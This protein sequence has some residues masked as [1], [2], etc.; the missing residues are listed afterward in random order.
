[1]PKT[2]KLSPKKTLRSISLYFAFLLLLSC[3]NHS[4]DTIIF[5]D[6]GQEITLNYSDL[7]EDLRIIELDNDSEVL[8][9]EVND[10]L[11]T[12]ERIIILDKKLSEAIHFYNNT[13]RLINSIKAEKG[14]QP[15]FIY[16]HT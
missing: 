1:M 15:N 2:S 9:A 13:G 5:V 6:L 11:I 4:E 14:F 3:E 10:V 12:D 8:V 7:F 16:L